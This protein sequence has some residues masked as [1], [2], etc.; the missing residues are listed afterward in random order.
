MTFPTIV[1]VIG[2]LLGLAGTAGAVLVYLKMSM[3]KTT[4][5]LYRADNDALR[6]R[7]DTIE[8]ERDGFSS[9]LHEAEGR[10]VALEEERAI[11]RDLATGHSAI[12]TLGELVMRNHTET[13]GLLRKITA[14]RRSSET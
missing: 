13:M 10:I 7:V 6:S 4:I 12:E 9:K 14:D 2:G 5:E 3:A 11:L 8:D 1:G